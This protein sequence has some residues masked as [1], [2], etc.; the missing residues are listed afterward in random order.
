MCLNC[1][2]KIMVH[3]NIPQ[4]LEKTGFSKMVTNAIGCHIFY[5]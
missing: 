3:K 5:V 2:Q 1:E 4:T